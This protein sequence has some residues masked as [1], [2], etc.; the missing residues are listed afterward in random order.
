MMP[1]S[2]LLNYL[3]AAPF[4]PFQIRMAGER[5]YDIRHPEMIRVGKNSLIVFT[6]V[7]DEPDVYDRWETVSL[8]LI[9]SV[10]QQESLSA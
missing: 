7:T 3:R 9:E 1:P 4:R 10:T 5:T 6:F 8:M 2:E